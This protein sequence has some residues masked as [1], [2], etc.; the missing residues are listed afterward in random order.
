MT[1]RRHLLV[2]AIAFASAAS[3]DEGMWTFEQPP[4]RL[5]ESKHGFR[6]TPAWLDHL[7]LSALSVGGASGSF[8]SAQGLALTNHHVVLSCLEKLS[9]PTRDLVKNGYV[10]ATRA[11]ELACPGFEIKRLESMQDVTRDV[12]AAI[13]S[14]D[15][16]GANA[17][18]N[19]VIARIEEACSRET[20]LRCEVDT[21]FRGAAYELLRY[22]L[23][24]DARLV[25]AP[26]SAV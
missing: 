18:R 23:W 25:F 15:G 17:E 7:R 6:L 13:R 9:T 3:A 26:E 19:T 11:D 24:T 1:A 5:V 8:V 16:A 22:K 10:A 20:G 12:Q 4:T 14:T 2:A 21:R